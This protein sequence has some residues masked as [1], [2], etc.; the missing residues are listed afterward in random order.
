MPLLPSSSSQWSVFDPRTRCGQVYLALLLL[1]CYSAFLGYGYIHPDEWMQSGEPYFGFTLSGNDA[2]IPWEWRPDQALRSISSLRFRYVHVDFLL[3]LSRKLS[4]PLSGY[5]LFLIQR[6]CML[7]WTLSLDI[8][9]LDFPPKTARYILCLFSISTAA[10]TFLVRPFTN[11]HEAN[12]VATCLI[13]ALSFYRNRTWYRPSGPGWHWGI[14]L[15]TILAVEGLFARFTFAIFSFPI[16]LFIAYTHIRIAKQGYLKPAVTSFAIA[17]GAAM[18]ALYYT[19]DSETDFYTRSAKVNKL[20]VATLWRSKWVIPPVNALLYNAKTENVAQHGL[21]PRWLHALVN[22]PMMVGV[23]NCVVVVIHGWHFVKGLWTSSANESSMHDSPAGSTKAGPSDLASSKEEKEER[24]AVEQAIE[25]SL[26]QGAAS[27]SSSSSDITTPSPPSTSETDIEYVDIE[28]IAVGLSLTIIVFSLA[29]LSISPHQEPRFLLALTFPSTIIMAYALQSP[30]FTLRPVVLRTLIS[31][32]IL[33]H[34]LQLLLFSF[35]HQ[36]AVL[37]TLFSIDHSISLLPTYGDPLF[38]RYEHHLLYRTFS[39][40]FHLLPHKGRGMFAR[41]EHYDSSWSPEYLV[42]MAS[43]ACNHTWMY[44]PTWIVSQ[45]KQIAD[46][47]GRV[48][49][50]KVESF[51]WHVDMDHLG[52]S[53]SSVKDLG[54]KEAFAIQKLHVRCTSHAPQE[55]AQPQMEESKDEAQE[56]QMVHEEL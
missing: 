45:L 48:E 50:V 40:P 39:V 2:R 32:H 33:Q 53:W 55:S 26:T 10:T 3:Y 29:M 22:L 4:G 17:I 47:R 8:Y 6:T 37:P 35:L 18:A 36:A 23:A 20:E 44:A 13:S 27:M 9:I 38:N 15:P 16:G 1:R 28:P 5:K 52:Q 31:V 30:F 25:A 12:I 51:N 34:L 54:L 11:S 41:I 7:L 19:V 14:L 43:I 24:K 42:H 21:H 49:L 56:P 46:D